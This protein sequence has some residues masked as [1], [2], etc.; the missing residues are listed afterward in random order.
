MPQYRYLTYELLDAGTIARIT[1]NRPGS[2]NAQNL[3]ERT[4][5]FARRIAALP[6]MA[7]LHSTASPAGPARFRHRYIGRIDE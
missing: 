3:P 1:L 2:R 7:A 5:E 6:T 4:V